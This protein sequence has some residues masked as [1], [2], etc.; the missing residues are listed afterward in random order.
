MSAPRVDIDLAKIE[1][2]TRALV[3]R[4]SLVGIRVVGITKAALGNPEIGAAMMDG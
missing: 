1:H 4:L 3:D 2:N